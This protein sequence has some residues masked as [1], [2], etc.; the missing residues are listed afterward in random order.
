MA[1]KRRASKAPTATKQIII[2]SAPRSPARRAGS[3]AVA[4]VRRS[5][6][7]VRRL[8]KDATPAVVAGGAVI[9]YLDGSGKL[10]TLPEI[11][12]SR[13]IT[14]GLIG[15]AARKFSKN[16]QVKAAGMAAMTVASFDLGRGIGATGA[17]PK[18]TK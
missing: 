17:L 16:P 11:M 3:R 1:K 12:G 18:T 10:D 9:G 8:A 13:M 15:Y 5:G 2:A 14:L 7:A 4:V 6:A